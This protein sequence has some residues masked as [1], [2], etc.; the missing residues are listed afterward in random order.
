MIRLFVAVDLPEKMQPTLSTMGGTIAGSR[1][2]P[3]DQLHLTLKFIGEVDTAGLVDVKESL[4]EIRFS[5]FNM[6]LK[7]V[8]HF[9]PRGEPKVIW[10]GVTPTKEVT[11]LRNKIEKALAETG[12]PREKR[13]FSAHLTLCRLKNTPAQKV[14][15]FLAENSFFESPEFEVHEF[16][17]YSSVLSRK[18]AI[19]TVEDIFKLYC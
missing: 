5:P 7:G 11:Q 19:H 17:L 15:R 6:Q 16:K 3:P 18:G 9:P 12:I 1:P 8:G 4:Q 13:K 10:A 14:A 2:V